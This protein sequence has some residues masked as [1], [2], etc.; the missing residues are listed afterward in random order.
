MTLP[1]DEAAPGVLRGVRVHV[2]APYCGMIL[3]DA[4][5]EV[6][7]EADRGLGLRASNGETFTFA[8]LARRLRL[9]G[10]PGWPPLV[11][12]HD[13]A[14]KVYDQVGRLRDEHGP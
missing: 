10:P 12:G 13:W 7:R 3:R 1:I 9:P 6:I 4:G 2:A 11:C 8:S 14:C 5:A